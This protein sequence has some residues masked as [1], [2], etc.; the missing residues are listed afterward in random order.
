[1][2]GSGPEVPCK[3]GHS[4]VNSCGGA[5]CFLQ[6]SERILGAVCDGA[7]PKRRHHISLRSLPTLSVTPSVPRGT[8][9]AG[10]PTACP[11]IPRREVGKEARHA[12]FQKN[13]G[14]DA[15]AT[16]PAWPEQAAEGDAASAEHLGAC[17]QKSLERK[18]PKEST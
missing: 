2:V 6:A 16:T 4:A 17:T 11:P 15:A 13:K 3:Q 9:D 12:A 14:A 10:L 5:G 18:T 7:N 8:Q 1:M